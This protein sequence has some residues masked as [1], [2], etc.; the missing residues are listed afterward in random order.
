MEWENT[1]TEKKL[2]SRRKR[3]WVVMNVPLLTS[4]F[5]MHRECQLVR[6]FHLRIPEDTILKCLEIFATLHASCE[7]LG[8]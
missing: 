7:K 3:K 6:L 1:G 5:I 4:L 2:R 8:C